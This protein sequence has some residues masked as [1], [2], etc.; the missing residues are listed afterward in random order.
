MEVLTGI[1]VDDIAETLINYFELNRIACLHS[2]AQTIF[3]LN[4]EEVAITGTVQDRDFK[5]IIIA[6]FETWDERKISIPEFFRD[7][8]DTGYVYE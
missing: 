5:N 3:D 7:A 6:N 8:V 2:K 1:K 4:G